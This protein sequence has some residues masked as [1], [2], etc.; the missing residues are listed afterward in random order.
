MATPFAC[1]FN[2]FYIYPAF[3]LLSHKALHPPSLSLFLSLCLSSLSLV[4]H[5]VFLI[6]V[7]PWGLEMLMFSSCNQKFFAVR[8]IHYPVN[9]SSDHFLADAVVPSS[10]H[11]RTETLR[12]PSDRYCIVSVAPSGDHYGIDIVVPSSD[13]CCTETVSPSSDHYGTTKVAPNPRIQTRITSSS[14]TWQTISTLSSLTL[15][16]VFTVGL[17]HQG[18]LLLWTFFN[19]DKPYKLYTLSP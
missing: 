15:S 2:I 7:I 1:S 3:I 16:Q 10:D 5:P 6:R 4:T 17:Y 14:K 18:L 19:H 8:H 12:P 13:H 9:P 11:C